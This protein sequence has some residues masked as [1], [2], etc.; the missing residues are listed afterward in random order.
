MA[1]TV[2]KSTLE[3]PFI[4][5]LLRGGKPAYAF[6]IDLEFFFGIGSVAPLK[7]YA[8]WE[9]I[10]VAAYLCPESG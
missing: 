3:G 8:S 7:K 6:N 5:H 4:L 10:L 2:R 1:A 9:L